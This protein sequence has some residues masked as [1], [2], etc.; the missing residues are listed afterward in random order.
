MS[1]FKFSPVLES[2]ITIYMSRVTDKLSLIQDSDDNKYYV[3]TKNT[4]DDWT[5]PIW[6][7]DPFSTIEDAEIWCEQNTDMILHHLPEHRL[8]DVKC[9]MQLLGFDSD[10]SKSNFTMKSRLS[11]NDE[12][13]VTASIQN[14]TFYINAHNNNVA[15]P[16][17]KLPKPTKNIA[18]FI[19]STECFLIRCGLEVAS[20][21]SVPI[22]GAIN[23]HNLAQKLV[24]V[25]SSN[26]WGY[27]IN[28]K[29]RKDKFGDVIVQFK[30]K[31]GGPGDV[32]IYY[33]VPVL[34]YRRW[35]SAR[36]KGHYFWQYIRNYFKYSKLTGDKRG[37][38]H[39][40]VN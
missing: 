21:L 40:A 2:G 31:N 37:K 13:T 20:D 26:V 1:T 36:S 29:N 39:N 27:T 25:K 19:Y 3:R 10:I 5:Y 35:Q 8:E 11:N 16:S 18:K 15:L 22:E 34:T 9:A 17:Y 7:Y 14:D 38:L 28:V 30:D 12:L 33:D 32:Y 23:T 24:R 6:D 4:S